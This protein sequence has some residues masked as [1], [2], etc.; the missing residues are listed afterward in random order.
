MGLWRNT[1][2][3]WHVAALFLRNFQ[4][5][6]Y[7]EIFQPFEAHKECL[8]ITILSNFDESSGMMEGMENTF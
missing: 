6:I 7:K 1:S 3:V 8:K 4:Y 5:H 2:R